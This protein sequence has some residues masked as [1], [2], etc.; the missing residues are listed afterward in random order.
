MISQATKATQPKEED[1][2]H[3]ENGILHN[4]IRVGV[5]GKYIMYP[6]M[7][8]QMSPQQQPQ[9][10]THVPNGVVDPPGRTTTPDQQQKQQRQGRTSSR[11]TFRQHNTTPQEMLESEG[12][13]KR[14]EDNNHR[15]TALLVKRKSRPEKRSRTPL[16]HGTAAEPLVFHQ[17]ATN[18]GTSNNSRDAG[19]VKQILDLF[20]LKEKMKR[21]LSGLCG[22][23]CHAG[24]ED[25][26]KRS[27]ARRKNGKSNRCSPTRRTRALIV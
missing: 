9:A 24:N 15:S 8:S 14:M 2:S 16:P 7:P 5:N 13:H 11:H 3:P 22:L 25:Y 19:K 27:R 18:A 26:Y 17:T 20:S 21:S 10:T 23:R 12:I 4:S 6:Q 1:E